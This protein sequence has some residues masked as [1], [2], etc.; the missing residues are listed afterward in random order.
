MTILRDLNL[1]SIWVDPSYLA[2]TAGF[3][4][5]GHNL[6]LCGVLDCGEFKGY[7]TLEATESAAPNQTVE[8]LARPVS[9]IVSGSALVREVAD[10]FVNENLEMVA[11]VEDGKFHGFVTPSVLIRELGKSYDP[12]TGLPWSD[13][14]RRWG[15]DHLANTEEITIVFIDLNDFGV[16]NKTHGHIIGDQVLGAVSRFLKSKVDVKTDVLVRYGGDEF[17]IGTTRSREETEA[18]AQE[19]QTGMP[20]VEIGEGI[21]PVAFSV[22]LCGGRRQKERLSVHYAATIDNLINKASQACQ[23]QK[24]AAKGI[25][26]P[27]PEAAPRP[28][29]YRVV[30]VFADPQDHGGVSTVILNRG[31]GVFS[32]AS[33]EPGLTGVVQAA[34][35]AIE[36]AQP[37][38]ALEIS[39]VALEGQTLT[40]GGKVSESLEP[41][42]LNVLEELSG[43]TNVAAV[44]ALTKALNG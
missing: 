10:R 42:D 13:E 33:T 30:A 1:P 19:L 40:V 14:L 4:M 16:Y 34:A 23:A 39:R 15:A 41:R 2:T 3:V 20:E 37:G 27:S 5:K 29:S 7:I 6:R 32:G 17:A 9:A 31:D 18:L 26:A 35:R 11:V 8:S 44:T 36:M 25:G 43:D 28:L 12:M 22:G 21:E 38:I 24:S